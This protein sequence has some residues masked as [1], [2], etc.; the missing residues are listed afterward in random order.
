[1]SAAVAAVFASYKAKRPAEIDY[2]ALEERLAIQQESRGE[3]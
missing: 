3:L 2:E 1:V